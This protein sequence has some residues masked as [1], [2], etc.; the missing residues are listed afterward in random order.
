MSLFIMVV[1][2]MLG[3]C[4]AMLTLP[5]CLNSL[6]RLSMVL[7][8]SRM[9]QALLFIRIIIV[10]ICLDAVIFLIVI[11][12]LI[13]FVMKSE[14]FLRCSRLSKMELLH[15]IECM[16]DTSY[17]ACLDSDCMENLV[18]LHIDVHVPTRRPRKK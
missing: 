5:L 10:M 2:I 11:F 1:V 13:F 9:L 7:C 8:R 17:D 12:V 18:K 14:L 3:L 16:V 6:I 15:L 4:L